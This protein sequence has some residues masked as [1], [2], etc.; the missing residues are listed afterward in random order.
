MAKLFC[1]FILI[2]AFVLFY[3]RNP[4]FGIIII[5][6]FVA[7]FMFFKLRKHGLGSNGLSFLSGKSAAYNPQSNELLTL[8][9]LQGL[10]NN[11]TSPSGKKDKE[12]PISQRE[13][14]IDRLKE[15]IL[16]L[17]DGK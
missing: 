8:L 16:E 4:L 10:F 17:L 14:E 5:V 13:K 11:N 6:L 1:Y 3:Q 9:L 2:V 15:E 7:G 12:Q